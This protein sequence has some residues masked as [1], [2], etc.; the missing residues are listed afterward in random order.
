MPVSVTSKETT[1]GACL[2]VGWSAFQPLA[3]GDT[4]SFTP[5]S[6][7][8]LKALDSRFFKTCCRRF[9]SVMMLRPARLAEIS[10][11]NCSL[12]FS[13]SCRN[14]RA[15]ISSKLLKYTSSASTETVP[16]SIFD[17]SRISLMR[18]NRS[19]PAP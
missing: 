14:G 18:F 9:E 13:A 17:R 10:T 15:I 16:D 2:N 8:N 1:C 7:V 11:S 19:V 12:R 6:A 3:A 5:P 4:A